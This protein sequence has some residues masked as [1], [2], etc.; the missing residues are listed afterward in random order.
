MIAAARSI[1]PKLDLQAKELG[2]IERRYLLALARLSVESVFS[3]GMAPELKRWEVPSQDIAEERACFV[4]INTDGDLRG[5]IGS[6]KAYRPLVEDVMDNAVSSAFRD[7]RFPPL[8]REEL[9]L[10][11]FSISVLG[12]ASRLM[13][14][15]PDELL[16]KLEQGRHGLIICKEKNMATY[17]PYV[18]R[19]FPTKADF[20]KNLC[21]KAGLE[22]NE[23]LEPRKMDIFTYEAQEFAE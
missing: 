6:L 3:E 9:P 4:T 19:L 2:F 17:L 12:E 11:S 10:V 21:M 14:S 5:C 23:W 16:A 7:Q 20:L 8:R 18:W 15:E 13:A 1:E 22:A